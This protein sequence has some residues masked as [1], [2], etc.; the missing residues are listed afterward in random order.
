MRI[1]LWMNNT[2]A[3]LCFYQSGRPSLNQ[4]I[5]FDSNCLNK[6]LNSS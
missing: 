5:S 6:Y 1:N 3:G 2:N 4:T